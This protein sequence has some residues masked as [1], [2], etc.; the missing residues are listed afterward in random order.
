M[1]FIQIAL[2][3]V[4]FCYNLFTLTKLCKILFYSIS[5]CLY[6]ILFNAKHNNKIY[7]ATTKSNIFPTF[8][9]QNM[10]PIF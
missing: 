6:A 5:K 8:F 1:Y 2:V 7:S 9:S 4:L 10:L 3:L